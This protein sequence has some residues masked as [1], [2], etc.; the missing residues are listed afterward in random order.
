MIDPKILAHIDACKE[1]M[2]SHV[3]RRQANFQLAEEQIE[4]IAEKAATKALGKLT[5]LAYREVGRSVISKL[6]WIT[7]VLS[8]GLY[9]YAKSRNWVE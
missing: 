7:G 5:D 1:E 4:R 6:F 2:I 8:V 3:D 9:L